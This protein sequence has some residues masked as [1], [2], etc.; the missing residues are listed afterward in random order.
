MRTSSVSIADAFPISC[1]CLA[2]DENDASRMERRRYSEAGI[3]GE[4]ASRIV[5]A[6]VVLAIVA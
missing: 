5:P 3:T 4:A 6:M 1:L 2:A